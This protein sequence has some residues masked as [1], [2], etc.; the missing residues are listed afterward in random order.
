MSL[1]LINAAKL[2]FLIFST[3][4]IKQKLRNMKM[5]LN[6]YFWY[7]PHRVAYLALV[8]QALLWLAYIKWSI[9][10][11]SYAWSLIR[12]MTLD[13]ILI[14]RLYPV[15]FSFFVSTHGQC[16]LWCTIV[17][18][19][20]FCPCLQR[21]QQKGFNV[22]LPYPPVITKTIGKFICGY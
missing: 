14:S 20:S 3:M 1:I 18:W 12:T 13:K 11:T 22:C 10:L 15:T 7:G 8:F 6:I 16:L 5:F 4:L 2:L 9:S 17:I 19:L 21:L